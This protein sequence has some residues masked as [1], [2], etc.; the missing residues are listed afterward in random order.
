[1]SDPAHAL[2]LEPKPPRRPAYRWHDGDTTLVFGALV[3]LCGMLILGKA[4]NPD[5]WVRLPDPLPTSAMTNDHPTLSLEC[6]RPALQ[7]R[8]PHQ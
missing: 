7:L 2:N 5:N 8:R 4:L 1:M 3:V 6:P